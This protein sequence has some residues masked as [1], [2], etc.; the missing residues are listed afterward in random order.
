MYFLADN[1]VPQSHL[2]DIEVIRG[3]RT[4]EAL[5]FL[6]VSSSQMM[7]E[8]EDGVAEDRALAFLAFFSD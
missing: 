4:Y 5:D 6:S 2:W 1:E 7:F 3:W 8:I